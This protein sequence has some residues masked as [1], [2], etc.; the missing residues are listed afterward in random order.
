MNVSEH[1]LSCLA[2]ECAE[3]IQAVTKAL[4]FGPNGEYPENGVNNIA[5]IVA[6]LSD[7][8]AVLELLEEYSVMKVEYH[9]PW[10]ERKKLRVKDFMEY[11]KHNQ[12]ALT[13]STAPPGLTA[14]PAPAI[15]RPLPPGA[16]IR[17][18]MPGAT[19]TV[20][21]VDDQGGDTLEVRFGEGPEPVEWPWDA[22][23]VPEL[24][25]M[26]EVKGPVPGVDEELR[27]VLRQILSDLPTNRD[28]LD[29]AL[30]KQARALVGDNVAR[31]EVK[32]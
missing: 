23:G 12:G 19:V 6:E 27:Y 29:P 24:V 2:E 14:D 17:W 15:S 21:V 1:L 11:A 13:G 8:A 16:V 18:A 10:I 31:A 32:P 20:T 4:R 7:V 28:W 26:P 9:R 5:M 3:V 22:D 25:S 30:E